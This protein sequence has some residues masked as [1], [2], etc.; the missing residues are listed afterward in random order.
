MF[1]KKRSGKMVDITMTRDYITKNILNN[2]VFVEESIITYD[3]N[4]SPIIPF[5]YK[6][7]VITGIFKKSIVFSNKNIAFYFM[8]IIR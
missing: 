2:H 4:N 3:S 7:Y 8:F 5:D 1:K 6:V